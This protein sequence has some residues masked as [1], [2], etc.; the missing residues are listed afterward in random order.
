MIDIENI[1]RTT[2][3]YEICGKDTPLKKVSSTSGGEYAGPC[4][5]CGGN[6]RFRIQPGSGRWLCRHCTDGKWHDVIEYIKRR[7]HLDFIGAI[8][9]LGGPSNYYN[10]TNAINTIYSQPLTAYEPP[11]KKWQEAANLT[12]KIC[13]DN[14][15]GP[16][17][18]RVLDYLK[19]KRGLTDTTINQYNLGYSFGTH[20]MGLFIPAGIVI[21][22]I[23]ADRIWYLKIRTNDPKN[24]YKGV[25]GNKP[26]A[27]FNADDLGGELALIVEGEFDCILA[28]QEIG[29]FLPVITAGGATNHPDLATWGSY[30]LQLRCAFIA[31]DNDQ[32]GENCK[33]AWMN[34]LGPRGKP[35]S[36]P[37]DY[38]DLTD[39][40]QAGGDL[41]QWIKP[42]LDKYAPL[43]KPST[44]E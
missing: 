5:M 2:N 19:N 32:A 26:A 28:S 24:K 40:H 25:A 4:P 17:G 13:I 33:N 8:K 10:K 29:V 12:I 43:H 35:V 7:D 42:Y 44:E 41:W 16:Q 38:K 23:V 36:V 18:N 3:L 14:L 34:T 37:A 11:P 22:C 15:W 31:P 30:L 9:K 6:D 20:V 39:Y 27:I 21:P 1:K